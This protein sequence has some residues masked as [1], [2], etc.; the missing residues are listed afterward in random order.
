MSNLFFC[1]YSFKV[2]SPRGTGQWTYKQEEQV[3]KTCIG[4]YYEGHRIRG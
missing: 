2:K 1:A 4:I 3:L